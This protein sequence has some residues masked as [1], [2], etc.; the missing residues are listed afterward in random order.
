MADHS[1]LSPSNAHRWLNCT[2]A[3]R[4]EEQFPDGGASIYADKGTLA[5]E[6][7]ENEIQ[8]HFMGLSKRA[9]TMK[10]NRLK[11]DE[12]YEPRMLETADF[13]YR[14]ILE[15]YNSFA[16]KP[17][18]TA[19]VK[20]DISQWVPDG[21]GRCDCV[22]IGGDTLMI[23]DYKNGSGVVVSAVDNPQMR[24]YALGAI[25]RYRAIYSGIKKIRMA[26]VQPNVTEDVSTDEVSVE[27]LYKWANEIVKPSAEKAFMG[28]G[29]FCSGDWCR[30]CRGKAKCRARADANSAFSDFKDVVPPRTEKGKVDVTKDSALSDE[31][32]GGLLQKAKDLSQWYADL[33]EYATQRILS[34]HAVKGWKI[35]A[36]RSSGRVFKDQDAAFKKLLEKKPTLLSTEKPLTEDDLYTHDKKTLPQIEKAIGAKAFSEIFADEDIERPMGKP[37]LATESDKRAAYN[38]AAKDFEGLQD[39]KD[40]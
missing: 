22:L 30:F 15:Q 23:V 33:K 25:D 20:V 9:H 32:I 34:G 14:Y 39:N 18:V 12:L 13:Y 8:Y 16:V 11:K 35:V 6:F 17:Y 3:P 26:I 28:M 19:E 1:L 40:K 36:G 7:C 38:P 5:H 10:I 21:F 37:T 24:L 4:F 29:T 2:A 27:E 31:E